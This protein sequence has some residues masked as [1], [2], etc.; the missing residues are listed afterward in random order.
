M[1]DIPDVRRQ[2][3]RTSGAAASTS[4]ATDAASHFRG[5]GRPALR[6]RPGRPPAAAGMDGAQRR[7]RAGADP[8]STLHLHRQ[9]LR[10]RRQLLAAEDL[11]WRDPGR[12]DVLRFARPHGWE[13]VTNFGDLP[14]PMPA[15]DVLVA[16]GPLADGMLP[17][18]T[19]AW[20]RVT[21]PA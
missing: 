3:P 4:A 13:V 20:L 1:A 11:E 10:L 8:G 15:G 21:A 9:T 5:A 2:D 14:V 7:R 16:S 18:E 12:P 19:A 17:A 6:L